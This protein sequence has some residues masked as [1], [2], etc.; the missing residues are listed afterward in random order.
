MESLH[1]CPDLSQRLERELARLSI[2]VVGQKES[3]LVLAKITDSTSV[4]NLFV[5]TRPLSV[6]EYV[7]FVRDRVAEFTPV[8]IH[9]GLEQAEEAIFDSPAPQGFG[10]MASQLSQWQRDNDVSSPDTPEEDTPTPTPRNDNDSET[11]S[12]G[13]KEE[14]VIENASELSN[15][16]LQDTVKLSEFT[17]HL[18]DQMN[19]KGDNKIKLGQIQPFIDYLVNHNFDTCRIRSIVNDLAGREFSQIQDLNY[20]KFSVFVRY[21]LQRYS[22]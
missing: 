5:L 12:E 17:R 21:F 14:E 7:V 3:Q 22:N 6:P 4:G 13:E 9:S 16:L 19:T 11:E 2:T 18:Y 1:Q 10:E 15:K 8:D 20:V